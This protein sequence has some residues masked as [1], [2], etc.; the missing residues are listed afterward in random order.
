MEKNIP[1]D[2]ESYTQYRKKHSP[3]FFF[4]GKPAG[5]LA[6]DLSRP[7]IDEAEKLLSGEIKYFSHQFH[8]TGF[9]PNW[10]KDYVTL[11]R[12]A[13]E[14]SLPISSEILRFAQN[15]MHKHW[16]QIPDDNVAARRSWFSPKQSPNNAEIAS[17]SK[18]KSDGSQRHGDIK[19][20][21]EPNRFA[22]VYTLVRAYSST[23]DEKYPQA[24]WT[25]IEDWAKQN[26]PNTGANWKDGQEIALRLMAWTFGYYAF[27]NSPSSTPE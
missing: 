1:S 9:P 8:K 22:F 14:E 21:W 6:E 26:P 20:I 18:N 12:K 4:N 17:P 16:S 27:L 19:F 5:Q 13:S 3:K 15:D 23:Q 10:H 11:S 24:F 7:A 25:L 2:I